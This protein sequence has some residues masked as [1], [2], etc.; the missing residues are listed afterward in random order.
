MQPLGNNAPDLLWEFTTVHDVD[1]TTNGNSGL[2]K[3]N[4]LQITKGGRL[5]QQAIQSQIMS[6]VKN[7]LG[8]DIAPDEPLMDAGMD[9]LGAVEFKN[10][11]SHQLGFELPVTASFDYPSVSALARYVN[12]EIG[13]AI[14]PEENY[15]VKEIHDDVNSGAFVVSNTLSTLQSTGGARLFVT[16]VASCTPCDS[17]DVDH[18]IATIYGK[19]GI[20]AVP[21]FRWDLHQQQQQ[22]TGPST[23]AAF[24][25]F[26]S[27]VELFDESCF[28]ISGA[29]ASVMDP[30]QR[31]LLRCSDQA[32]RTL[33]TL[34]T[35]EAAKPNH[36]NNIGVFV[37]IS[38]TDFARLLMT[39][40][41]VP[42][43][44]HAA[45]GGALSVA[46]GRLSYTF[47]AQGP[48]V[49]VETACSSSLVG[50]HLASQ[51]VAL[52]S[53]DSALL[54]GVNLTLDPLTT[55]SFTWSGMLAAD[56]R[57]KTLD[58]AADGYV[59]SEGCVA[60]MTIGMNRDGVATKSSDSIK[61]KSSASLNL[62]VMLAGSAVMQDG[63]SSSL[64]APNGPAQQSTIRQALSDAH[65]PTH[66]VQLLELHGTGTALG[67]P[68]EMGSACAVLNKPIDIQQRKGS[69]LGVS[70]AKSWMG[71]GESAAGI[72]GL[73][74]IHAYLVQ[75]L[76]APLL[77][78][79]QLSSHV[80]SI[81]AAKQGR[82]GHF[83]HSLSF[84]KVRVY[85]CDTTPA[86]VT[87]E[88]GGY[89]SLFGVSSFAFQGTNAH[90]LLRKSV[91]GGTAF[92]QCV[93][94]MQIRRHWP[95]VSAHPMLREVVSVCSSTLSANANL[96][97]SMRLSTEMWELCV[98][99]ADL[100]RGPSSWDHRVHNHCLVP[101]TVL[102]EMGYAV[103]YRSLHT[104]YVSCLAVT[105]IAMPQPIVIS[106]APLPVQC[107]SF[108]DGSFEVGSPSDRPSTML[109]TRSLGVHMHGWFV[110]AATMQ[111]QSRVNE[112]QIETP[113]WNL[114][115]QDLFA[116]SSH[117]RL[118]LSNTHAKLVRASVTG[119]LDDKVL[120]KNANMGYHAHASSLESS[121]QLNWAAHA[122]S[123]SMD[124]FS[125]TSTIHPH[126]V[127]AIDMYCITGSGS[128]L[129][130]QSL[131]GT[132]QHQASM[133]SPYSVD[134][135][136]EQ[137]ASSALTYRLVNTNCSELVLSI[138]QLRTKPATLNQEGALNLIHAANNSN[139]L[140]QAV[141]NIPMVAAAL[142]QSDGLTHAARK[143]Q[144]E[145]RLTAMVREMAGGELDEA[146]LIN[147]ETNL[148]EL[149]MQSTDLVELKN[150]IE[151][152]LQ[153]E[154]KVTALFDYPTLEA[155][156]D[157]ISRLMEPSAAHVDRASAS[158]QQGYAQTAVP[159]SQLSLR[160]T[161]R[162]GRP[163]KFVPLFLSAPGLGEGQLSY[164]QLIQALD[165]GDQP[166][167]TLENSTDLTYNETVQQVRL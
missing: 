108:A 22:H 158:G 56:G 100:G 83:A 5:D 29:E 145:A 153:V 38:A 151:S 133:A 123:F 149:S 69:A 152:E 3:S 129:S 91:G 21:L 90:A 28:G 27:D 72:V 159:D 162:M 35:L 62:N 124:I 104:P 32:M 157:H 67:D 137:E 10:I 118:S 26:L 78:L 43:S 154:L 66:S 87:P 134:V 41:V 110:P 45:P 114:H 98:F 61:G 54:C 127:A 51:S 107:R 160:R 68:I 117:S 48:A 95:F 101:G 120:L 146:T 31:L 141:G 23:P 59:R 7:V 77:H 70:S 12:S 138:Q 166:V 34:N 2:V 144:V 47:G 121:L 1:T 57:C 88:Q 13:S 155:L 156:S 99:S 163:T 9:S 65:S 132:C 161:L 15:D 130:G 50:T 30:Q 60:M 53:A 142:T 165:V 79:H 81:L 143:A 128:S 36:G 102:L 167:Y 40:K 106:G 49:C 73:A 148:T 17:D 85:H 37:G 113:Q 19:D 46:S 76:H 92:T 93:R 16:S 42:P 84:P 136:V 122:A 103:G 125:Q 96:F 115:V 112:Q 25:G 39:S 20:S 55:A 74:R 126:I 75:S 89:S 119:K 109:S 33:N 131:L 52:G 105:E 135:P 140:V 11:I 24:G 8:A 6:A 116:A 111:A 94:Q 18:R 58:A 44:A 63:R 71:H 80:T 139:Q 147:P 150:T 97:R 64:I 86:S 82:E 164:M 4:V 14:L